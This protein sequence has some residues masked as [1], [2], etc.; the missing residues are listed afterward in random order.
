MQSER[1]H[2]AHR[3][4]HGLVVD[5]YWDPADVSH[6]FHVHVVERGSG[7]GFVLEPTSGRAAIEAFHHPFASGLATDPHPTNPE[8]DR[9]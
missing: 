9:P 6:E 1:T 2:F 8:V 5:L 3:E 4:A 7:A